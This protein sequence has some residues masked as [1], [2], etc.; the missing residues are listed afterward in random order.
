MHQH[1]QVSLMNYK[2]NDIALPIKTEV[3][4]QV[5]QRRK[6]EKERMPMKQHYLKYTTIQLCYKFTF[7]NYKYGCDF[8]PSAE[9]HQPHLQCEKDD[10]K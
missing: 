5:N 6:T 9:Y 7:P 1:I 8:H 4:S 2:P 3:H 10:L